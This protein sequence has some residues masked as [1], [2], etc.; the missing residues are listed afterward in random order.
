MSAVGAAER[1]GVV[2]VVV[3][4][5]FYAGG[6]CWSCRRFGGRSAST[7][8]RTR[9]RHVVNIPPSWGEAVALW[10]VVVPSA[11]R[12][13]PLD[14]GERDYQSLDVVLDTNGDH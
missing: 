14:L 11:R 4:V 8:V 2:C 6:C 9:D 7:T 10:V 12:E 3:T 13:A 5:W 1:L